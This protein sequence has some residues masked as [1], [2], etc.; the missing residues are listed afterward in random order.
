MSKQ[1]QIDL[2][3]GKKLKFRRTMIGMSQED[4]GKAVGVTFQQIQ[5]YEKGLNRIG[6]SRIYEISRILQVPVSYF[7]EDIS[8]D[9]IINVSSIDEINNDSP[10]KLV[11][12]EIADPYSKKYSDINDKEL[13]ILVRSYRAI[14]D[15]SVRSKMISLMRAIAGVKEEELL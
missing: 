11:L 5:K 15:Q 7:F 6:S 4:L 9:A 2:H 8:D 3:V 14:S 10:H 12:R 13:L 1:N